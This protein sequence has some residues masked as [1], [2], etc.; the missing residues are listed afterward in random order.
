MVNVGKYTSPMDPLGITRSQRGFLNDSIFF[1]LGPFSVV[2]VKTQ[3][4]SL[5]VYR[6]SWCHGAETVVVGVD[7]SEDS[8]FT[9]DSGTLLPV[10]GTGCV[11]QFFNY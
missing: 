3:N 9:L 8:C 6:T 11:L 10:E 1:C 2:R 5:L 7:S 4:V